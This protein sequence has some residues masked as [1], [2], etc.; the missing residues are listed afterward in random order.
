MS[1]KR[2]NSSEYVKFNDF[3]SAEHDVRLLFRSNDICFFVL[4][5]IALPGASNLLQLNDCCGD[6]GVAR[7]RTSVSVFIS[8]ACYCTF[9]TSGTLCTFPISNCT[10]DFTCDCAKLRLNAWPPTVG[11]LNIVFVPMFAYHVPSIPHRRWAFAE[12]FVL[13]TFVIVSFLA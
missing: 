2:F 11:I 9:R 7:V 4:I 5:C 13:E 3:I 1:Q 12:L 6:T 8:N 10:S